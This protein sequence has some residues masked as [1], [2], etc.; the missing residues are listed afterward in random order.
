MDQTAISE[1]DIRAIGEGLLARTLP[2]AQWTHQAHC[3]A[4]L[5]LLTRHPDIDLD[6]DLPGIIWRYNAAVGTANSDSDGYHETITRFYL[7]VL[8][9]FLSRQPADAP[10]AAL[11]RLFM[12]SRFGARDFPLDYYSKDRLMSVEARRVW[13]APDRRDFDFD[14]VPLDGLK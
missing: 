2:L 1:D 3:L 11:A 9:S 6:R 4:G 10:L 8:R 14:F 12:A 5:Y 13:V 7:Q